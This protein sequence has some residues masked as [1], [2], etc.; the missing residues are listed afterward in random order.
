MTPENEPIY[1]DC[2]ASNPM[3]GRVCTA[4]F[5]WMQGIQGNPEAVLHQHGSLAMRLVEKARLQISEVIGSRKEEIIFTSGATES[6]NLGLLGLVSYGLARGKRHLV[7]SSVEHSSVW[8]VLK[9]MENMGFLCD[10][11]GVNSHGSVDPQ[12]LLELVRPDTLLVSLMA[13]NNLT[14]ARQP[15]LEVAD[16]LKDTDVFFH[17]DAAQGF[18]RMNEELKAPQIHLMSISGH[19]IYGP[20][21][22]GALMVREG[23]PLKPIMFGGGQQNALRPGTLPAPLIAG[24]GLAAEL[25]ERE[26]GHRGKKCAVMGERLMTALEPLN[27]TYFSHA[28]TCLPHVKCLAIPGVDANLAI[29]VLSDQISISRGSA[30]ATS[31]TGPSPAL[32]AMSEDPAILDSVLRFSWSHETKEPDWARLVR[33]FMALKI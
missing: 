14:G 11:V 32:L 16:G 33:S 18:G 6:N 4:V 3:D 25:A 26:K 1:F 30:C 17:V 15:I 23:T 12:E 9:H 20:K 29:S 19:K 7:T 10:R 2:N 21:G 22:I 24:L 31:Q 28:Q 13:V 27:P 5:E 8:E